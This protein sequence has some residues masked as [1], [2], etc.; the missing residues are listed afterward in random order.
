[1]FESFEGKV[2][3]PDLERDILAFWEGN[4][5]FE[6]LVEKNVGKPPWSFIDGPIT[7]NNPMGVHHAWGRTY[8]DIFQRYRA[9]RGYNLRYQNGFDCQGLWVE[10]EVEKDL[11]LNSKRDIVDFGLEEFSRECRAR[12]EKFADRIV[13]QSRRLGQWMRWRQP[14]G[15]HSS[16]FTFDDNNIE[17]IWYFLRTCHERDW[18]VLGHRVMPW[19]WRCGTSLSQ[20]ELID[21]YQEQVDPSVYFKCP[22]ADRPG[23]NFLVWTTTPWTSV[24]LPT[25]RERTSLSGLPRRGR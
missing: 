12:V 9:M 18:L 1:M 7:A 21:S 13:E 3:Y 4:H 23:E 16:Y 10:V 6:K 5:I 15:S 14:D 22:I 19:C 8:K 25:A 2:H 24:P 17:H 20:H 11:G